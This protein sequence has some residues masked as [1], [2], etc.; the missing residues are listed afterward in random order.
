V[1]KITVLVALLS[2]SGGCATIM[3]GGPDLIPVNSNPPGA[4][5]FVD[6][7]QV[8]VTPMTVS[9]DRSRSQGNIRIEMPG[10]APVI[11]QRHKEINGWFWANLC[12]GGLV[13]IV[14]DL[15]TGD[16]KR[17]DDTPIAVGMQPAPGYAPPPGA[18]PAY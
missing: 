12:L 15:I 1:L 9:L 5:V 10:F 17:F 7:Q 3:A 11:V 4:A 18:P 8:G 6:G 14:V 16:I 2:A 13:G